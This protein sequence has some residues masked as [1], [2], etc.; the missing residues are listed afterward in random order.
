MEE[1]SE[2]RVVFEN[3]KEVIY[4]FLEDKLKIKIIKIFMS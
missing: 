4:Q 1:G 3:T 2:Q